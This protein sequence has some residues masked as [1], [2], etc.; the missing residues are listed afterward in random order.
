MLYNKKYYLPII[1]SIFFLFF[2]GCTVPHSAT[3]SYV[4]QF[5]NAETGL[6]AISYLVLRDGDTVYG[7]IKQPGFSNKIYVNGQKFK[8]K[9]VKYLYSHLDLSVFHWIDKGFGRRIITGKINVYIRTVYNGSTYSSVVYL[10]KGDK[11]EP[12]E[13]RSFDDFR[14][15]V[16]DCPLALE[17]INKGAE[18]LKMIFKNRNYFL[19]TAILIYNKGCE[20]I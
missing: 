6:G 19:S 1:M 14:K 5:T 16:K 3:Q 9:Q 17:T 4:E 10:Q 7:K 13:A 20:P 15:V 8:K 18:D 12:V 11:A 2:I